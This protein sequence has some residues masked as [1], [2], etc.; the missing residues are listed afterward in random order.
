M[1]V[2]NPDEIVTVEVRDWRIYSWGQIA[3]AG[4][5]P[6]GSNGRAVLFRAD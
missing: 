6:V 4:G 5:M 3:G 1:D 2:H